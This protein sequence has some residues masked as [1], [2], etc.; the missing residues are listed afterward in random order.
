MAAFE[1]IHDD[2]P[3]WY[4]DG[5]I[6][7]VHI[8]AYRDNNGDGIG[9]IR[10]I[11]EK[12]DYIESLGVTIIW[13]L[14]F[15]PS[16]LRDDG[17]DTADYL[18]VNPDYGT[19]EDFKELLREAHKRNIRVITELVLNHTSDQHE[20]FQ[21]ARTSPAGSPQRNF[22]VWSD[23]PDK[24]KDARIIFSD[25][26]MSNWS[27]DPVA[28]AYFWH[29]FYSH[30]P[31][32]NFENPV[33]HKKLFKIVDFWLEMGVDG[34]R[35][36]A[37]PYLY[38]REGTNCENLPETHEF[39]KKLSAHVK[40]KFKNRML[41]AEAN[42][43][44]EDA[45]AYFGNGDEC[46]M[47]FHFPI[48]PRLYMSVQMEERYPIVD[49]IEQT[50]Q[51]P[52]NCQW[53]MF[54]RNHDELTLE[55]VTDEERD[56]MYRFYARDNRA[57]INLGIRRRL[58]PLV[59]NNRRKIELLN[60]LLFS[61]PGTPI[62]YYGDEI[63][64]GDNYY[65]GDRNGVRTPMQWSP[66]RNAGFSETNPQRLY[67]PVIFDPEY[68]YEA[69]NVEVQER[70]SS[71]LLWWM[72]KAI[73]TRNRFKAF[74]RGSLEL[75]SPNNSKVL[76]FIRK[77]EDETILIVTNLSK[78]SQVVELDLSKFTGYTPIEIFSGNKFPI[79][80]EISYYMLTLSGY[81]YYWFSLEKESSQN[82]DG[83]ERRI[84][85]VVL[86][87]NFKEIIERKE[88]SKIEEEVLLGY[89]ISRKDF[90]VRGKKIQEMNII[91]QIVI[92]DTPDEKSMMVLV[93]ITY[94]DIV[95][96]YYLLTVN[97]A[98]KEKGETVLNEYPQNVIVKLL[99]MGSNIIVY[100]GIISEIFRNH[101][102]KSLAAKKQI[103]G[104]RGFIKFN[105][106]NRLKKYLNDLKIR[107]PSHLIFEKEGNLE[108]EY[109]KNIRVKLYRKLEEGIH[110]G[111]EVTKFLSEKTSFENIS[112]YLGSIDYHREKQQNIVLGIIKEYVHNEGTAWNLFV[113]SVKNFTDSIIIKS[114]EANPATKEVNSIFDFELT[115]KI[116]NSCEADEKI[117]YE[118]IRLLGKR[119]AEMH[120]ALASNNNDQA[121]KPESFSLLYQRSIY[122]SLRS[123]IKN[124]FRILRKYLGEIPQQ[125]SDEAEYLL[126]KESELIKFGEGLIKEKF[127]AKKIRIHG[128]YHLASVLFTGKDFVIENFE[129]IPAV[130]LSER[131][132]K[133]SPLRDI[134]SMVW[135]L[136]YVAF[137]DYTLNQHAG[138][139]KIVFEHYLE[140]WWLCM[141]SVYLR[142]YM[143][144]IGN[145]EILPE[146]ENISRYLIHVYLIDKLLYEL[147]YA[148]QSDIDNVEIVL[149]ALTL[150]TRDISTQ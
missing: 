43:W 31:D 44:P 131:R 150:A 68:H 8:K 15:Y 35:L 3:L 114:K 117:N 33:V 61:F 149:R 19:I 41:L 123:S 103:T 75:L 54:L 56:Y 16:P 34:L 37:V 27:W 22:Y 12:L 124:S 47:A 89:I 50:P 38:E 36:D 120:L 21:K 81:D 146:E 17:Y 26:E 100:E 121:F 143:D 49:I 129:G 51:I 111:E 86:E 145:S 115:E 128:N 102:I 127:E 69:I 10:G 137:H 91:D 42:Q 136:F 59:E 2:N 4:K 53:A 55:M 85:E 107:I 101:F 147:R 144:K 93:K 95:P 14:P 78:F 105:I 109:E 62:I 71:S 122:Q 92:A 140:K 125:A 9:D 108:V 20:W 84:P 132:L 11:I 119:T 58:A 83:E 13:V 112:P 116:Y 25:F 98:K 118:R 28:K 5:I 134:A 64:M 94:I 46:Q 90:G 70:T 88:S 29:R 110:P 32:L 80:R 141:S 67:L 77:Y 142:S 135:S 57:R 30:Q 133:R 82:D 48:M 97:T 76:A 18:N 72:K 52:E 23:T 45:V 96:E 99:N 138:E 40:S 87:T 113:A 1:S 6:Y 60:I 139:N 106:S 39:L 148:L 130:P 73:R 7:Q 63:G 126:N 24:Y 66:D 104:K 65:L 74:G 79:V